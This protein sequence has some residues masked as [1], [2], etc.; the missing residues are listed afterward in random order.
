MA[1]SVDTVKKMSLE[2]GGNAAFIVFKSANME[3]AVKGAM[4]SK[5]RHTS[6]V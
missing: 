2:L 3:Q 6:Q 5:Y 4:A 1:K